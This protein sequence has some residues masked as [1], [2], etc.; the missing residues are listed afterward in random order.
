MLGRM[1]CSCFPSC[2]VGARASRFVF[3]RLLTWTELFFDV[4]EFCALQAGL[5]SF[6]EFAV[7]RCAQV[8]RTCDANSV[9]EKK[10]KKALLYRLFEM[11]RHFCNGEP[12]CTN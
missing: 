11:L 1:L 9:P 5:E 6:T 4:R 8:G 12:L 3:H 7:R 10:K 2:C